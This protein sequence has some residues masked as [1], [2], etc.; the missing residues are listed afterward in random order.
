MWFF[1]ITVVMVLVILA[2]AIVTLV[3]S[4]KI[5]SGDVAVL[6]KLPGYKPHL[7]YGNALEMARQPDSEY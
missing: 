5:R 3:I 6:R 7:L 4:L 2:L 1:L